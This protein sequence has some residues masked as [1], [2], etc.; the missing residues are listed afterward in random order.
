MT[1]PVIGLVK[2]KQDFLIWVSEGFTCTGVKIEVHIRMM[3]HL[4]TT[5]FTRLK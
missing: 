1:L 3:L 2:A 4:A 5:Y